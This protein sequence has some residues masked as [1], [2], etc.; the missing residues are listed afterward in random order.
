MGFFSTIGCGA[1]AAFVIKGIVDTKKE[2]RENERRRS[3]TVIFDDVLTEELFEEIVKL[4]VKKI[5]RIIDYEIDNGIVYATVRS[6]S[7]LTAWDFQLD[8]N[9]YGEISG[10]YWITSDNDDSEIPNYLGD[11]IQYLI[12]DL[13]NDND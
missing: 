13:Y 11:M 12:S 6:Q 5:N 8:F 4:C 3:N 1:A 2:K 7:G 10:T 9:D